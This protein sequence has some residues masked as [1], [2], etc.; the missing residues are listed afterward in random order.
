MA[1]IDDVVKH[2]VG[3]KKLKPKDSSVFTGW[4]SR[5]QVFFIRRRAE[6][7][8]A[9]EPSWASAAGQPNLRARLGAEYTALDG[10]LTAQVGKG[11]LKGP[12]LPVLGGNAAADKTPRHLDLKD[13][14]HRRTSENATGT[15]VKTRAKDMSWGRLVK[16]HGIVWRAGAL[17]PE[18]WTDTP[19]PGRTAATLAAGVLNELVD[20]RL[21]I[22]ERMQYQVSAQGEERDS[23]P[24]GAGGLGWRRAMRKWGTSVRG[25]WLDGFRIR[26]FEYPRI[27]GKG[28]DLQARVDPGNKGYIADP[29]KEKYLDHSHDSATDVNETPEAKHQHWEWNSDRKTRL[30]WR[31]LHGTAPATA[32]DEWRVPA[33]LHDDYTAQPDDPFRIHV[34]PRVGSTGAAAIDALFDHTRPVTDMWERS[35]LWC[36]HVICALHIDA[37]LFGLRRRFTAAT[38]EPTFNN[39]VNGVGLPPG[40]ITP[41]VQIVPL[42]DPTDANHYPVL[43][44]HTNSKHFQSIRTSADNLQ[45]GDQVIFWNH[46][47]YKLLARGDWRLENALVMSLDSDPATGKTLKVSIR[48][49]GH[50]TLVRRYPGFQAEIAEKI[51]GGLRAAQLEVKKKV[52]DVPAAARPSELTFR[53]ARLVRWTPYSPLNR[54][55]FGKAGKIE[56]HPW[57]VE[58]NPARTDIPKGTM[59]PAEH[60]RFVAAA[61]PKTFARSVASTVGYTPPPKG[62]HIYFPLFEPR[63]SVLRKTGATLPNGNPKVVKES[64]WVAYFLWHE[65]RANLHKPPTQMVNLM[66]LV[67]MSGELMPGLFVRPDKEIPLVRPIP[68]P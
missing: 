58:I 29:F 6:A 28:A 66:D 30:E 21:I 56:L 46:T 55:A 36:D 60:A 11:T 24:L 39:L 49:Q 8:A 54:V 59:T 5:Q 9:I 57:W 34:T 15:T 12:L 27:S 4:I 51:E 14:A 53:K 37:L 67:Q 61:L 7:I 47:L 19:G 43:F 17:H 3:T 68:S 16:V 42:I 63:F 10:F 38:G 18:I 35:W 40:A 2:F 50:G 31:V 20:R 44:T 23:D 33:A 45:L 26:L 65:A 48:L 62:D 41:Y 64:G 52:A 32:G 22:L 1:A 25:P 13:L